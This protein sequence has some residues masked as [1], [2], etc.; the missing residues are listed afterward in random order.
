MLC[1]ERNGVWMKSFEISRGFLLPWSK[2]FPRIIVVFVLP[3]VIY[4]LIFLS[5]DLVYWLL[6][7][8][9]ILLLCIFSL[10][11]F[12]SYIMHIYFIF[13]K[14][15]IIY[16]CVCVRARVRVCVC[17]CMR[18]RVCEWVSQSVSDIHTW[19]ILSNWLFLCNFKS[20]YRARLLGLSLVN[21]IIVGRY[22]WK[23]TYTNWTSRYKNYHFKEIITW[24]DKF[25][26]WV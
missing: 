21:R 26:L 18:A 1:F 17:V 8:P 11:I 2:G 22:L 15:C 13:I 5:R 23:F 24:I 14:I 9:H 16:M 19:Y 10:Y 4:F 7:D 12:L 6:V 20:I 25:V 3:W